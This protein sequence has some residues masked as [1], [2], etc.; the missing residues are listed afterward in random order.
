MHAHIIRF[1]SPDPTLEEGKGSGDFGQKLGPVYDPRR[2]LHACYLPTHVGALV[3]NCSMEVA[4]S[5]LLA[6]CTFMMLL[7]SESH[8]LLIYRQTI[9]VDIILS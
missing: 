2:N 4:Q 6:Y 3:S 1:S 8:S 5:E 9:S 7:P